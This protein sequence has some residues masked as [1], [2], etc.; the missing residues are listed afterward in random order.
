MSQGVYVLGGKC[1]GGKCP[2]DKCP[3]GKCPGVSVRGVSVRGVSVRGVSVRG[4]SVR[5]VYVL[6]VSVLGVSVRGGKCPGGICLWGKCPVGTCP[7][8]LCPR[9]PKETALL[10]QSCPRINLKSKGCP[11]DNFTSSQ[12]HLCFTD[13]LMTTKQLPLLQPFGILISS[14][15][16]VRTTFRR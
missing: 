13:C 2:G 16:F 3:G 6:G 5:G 9:T 11:T 15:H 7:G 4:V 14:I 1:P 12:Y 10:L 8:G